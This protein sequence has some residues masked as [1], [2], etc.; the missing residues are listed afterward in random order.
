MPIRID[1]LDPEFYDQSVGIP[2][3]IYVWE[4]QQSDV[5]PMDLSH[6]SR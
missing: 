2:R 1:E 5:P 3:R 4:A 6:T